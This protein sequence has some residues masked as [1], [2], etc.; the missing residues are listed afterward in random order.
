M[1]F[2]HDGAAQKR[3]LHRFEILILVLLIPVAVLAL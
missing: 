2:W 3:W 1:D